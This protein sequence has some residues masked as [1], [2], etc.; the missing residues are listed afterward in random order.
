MKYV[1]LSFSSLTIFSCT[2]DYAVLQEKKITNPHFLMK[3]KIEF[4][5]VQLFFP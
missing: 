4:Y 5:L 2:Y 3:M 1:I